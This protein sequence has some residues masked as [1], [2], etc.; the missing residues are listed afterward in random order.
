MIDWKNVMNGTAQL[1][2]CTSVVLEVG[3]LA[4]IR[5]PFKGD[6]DPFQ[7]SIC[8][9]KT[10]R[11]SRTSKQA[12]ISYSYGECVSPS[13]T[14]LCTT[15]RHAFTLT[16]EMPCPVTLWTRFNVTLSVIILVF[17]VAMSLFCFCY[18]TAEETA[19]ETTE[20]TAEETAEE[21]F[22]E[23]AEKTA[24]NTAE[25]YEV[26]RRTT[27]YEEDEKSKSSS[28]RSRS[29]SPNRKSRSKFP[30]RISDV[31]PKKAGRKK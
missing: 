23:T 8:P 6:E 13:G 17:I 25:D 12:V 29:R 4:Q 16:S 18:S 14:H 21:T 26:S 19:E 1:A 2:C 30:G 3:D 10:S 15:W 24:E 22:E 31:K 9:S 5:R 7:I 27:Y 28:R 20:E 11:T